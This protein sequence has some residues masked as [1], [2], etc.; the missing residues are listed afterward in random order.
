MT[1]EVRNREMK[2]QS[3]FKQNLQKEINSA[4]QNINNTVN[5]KMKMGASLADNPA[6][7]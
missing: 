3:N 2:M 1:N 6:L 5:E 7:Q 4:K